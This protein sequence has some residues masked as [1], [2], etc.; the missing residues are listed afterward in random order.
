MAKDLV[1]V[2]FNLPADELEYLREVADKRGI[3]VTQALRRAIATEK[4]I[5]DV[6]SSD[7]KLLIEQGDATREVIIR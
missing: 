4:L 7:S 1:K 2:S 3:N 6:D 5:D